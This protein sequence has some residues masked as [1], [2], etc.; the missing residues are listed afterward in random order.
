MSR[1]FVALSS[2]TSARR[3]AN[4]PSRR[5]AVGVMSVAPASNVRWNVLPSPGTPVLSTHTVPPISSASRRLIARP[6]PVPPYRR[7]VEA[8]AW[9]NDRNSRSMRSGGMPM[10]VSRTVTSNPTRLGRARAAR[11]TP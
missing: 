6:S 7:L 10:P 5:S 3:P 8:S 11:T 1:R 4:D 2:T 9:V